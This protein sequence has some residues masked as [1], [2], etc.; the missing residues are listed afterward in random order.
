MKKNNLNERGVLFLTGI[1]GKVKAD[2]LFA[3]VD[4]GISL[5]NVFG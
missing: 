3:C 2:V 1:V 4:G 5:M